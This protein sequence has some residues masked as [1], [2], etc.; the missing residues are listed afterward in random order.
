MTDG[1]NIKRI[2]DYCNHYDYLDNVNLKDLLWL[3]KQAETVEQQKE[4][5]RKLKNSLKIERTIYN[6]MEKL[7]K[8]QQEQIKKL[9][10]GE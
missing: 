1:Q 2:K 3:I 6:G 5:I 9:E 10:R 7:V 4:A 8:E